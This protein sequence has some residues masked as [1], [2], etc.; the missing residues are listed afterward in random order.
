MS[1]LKVAAQGEGGSWV[2]VVALKWQHKP[3][4]R[5]LVSGIAFI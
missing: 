5:G 2:G 3:R 1:T 4:G